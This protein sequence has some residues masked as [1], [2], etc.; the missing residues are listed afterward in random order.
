[1]VPGSLQDIFGTIIVGLLSVLVV[2][3]VYW[4]MSL[5]RRD[6]FTWLRSRPW[7]PTRV[8]GEVILFFLVFG[9]GHVVQD[10]ADHLTDSCHL[11]S[12][13][14]FSSVLGY[15]A[16]ILRVEGEHR[17]DT[18]FKTNKEKGDYELRGIGGELLS[19]KEHWSKRLSRSYS[20]AEALA[21]LDLYIENPEEFINIRDC[22]EWIDPTKEPKRENRIKIASIRFTNKIY[23]VCKNWCYLNRNYFEELEKIQRRIDFSR[24]SL[25]VAAFGLFL[26]FAAAT[27]LLV[28]HLVNRIGSRRE[29]SGNS[30][31][32]RTIGSRMKRIGSTAFCLFLVFL[33]AGMGYSHSEQNFNERAFGYY[34]SHLMETLEPEMSPGMGKEGPSLASI[35]WMRTSAEYQAICLQ[36]YNN[37][38]THI[39]RVVESRKGN[40]EEKELTVIM[41]LDETIL[42]NLGY[43]AQ[44]L[45][46]N[47]KHSEEAWRAWN[48]EH[49]AD[50]K[51]VP[52]AAEFINK[53]REKG[54]HVSFITNRKEEQRNTTIDILIRLGIL[55]CGDLDTGDGPILLFRNGGK[56]K[57]C[58]RALV[59]EKYEVIALIG[60]SLGDISETFGP[61]TV[62]TEEE[63]KEAVDDHR[64]LWGAKWFVL[65]NPLYGDWREFVDWRNP[66]KYF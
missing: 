49:G 40:G 12:R 30:S 14:R 22:P 26:M 5:D 18:L 29:G 61:E 35:L 8:F 11:E 9:M 57:K 37:A 33:L 25:L 59:E 42:D 43:N 21:C 23:Y 13:L 54:V 2:A 34:S 24:S 20:D 66:E 27:L 46:D 63:R 7:I 3:L 17:L 4:S 60:D 10:I 31:D 28:S 36:V 39:E 48:E 56:S 6:L 64:G 32:Q 45:F 19:F 50:I 16:N 53:V 1:M 62:K 47:Q 51:L 44:L 41:D 52:G 15:S 65:P 38:L 58:R 55:E